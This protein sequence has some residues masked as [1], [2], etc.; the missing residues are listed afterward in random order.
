MAARKRDREGTREV[1]S[2][3]RRER[4]GTYR[5]QAL[6]L[7]PWICASCGREFEGKNLRELTVHHKDHDHTHNPPDGSNWELLCYWCHDNEHS[8]KA[9]ADASAPGRSTRRG[10]TMKHSPFA[11]LGRLLDDGDS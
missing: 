5:E 3:H 10:D 7:L 9:V 4:Q 11:D 6:R 2:A 8:R 1:A